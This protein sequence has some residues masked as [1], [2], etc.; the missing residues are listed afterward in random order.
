MFAR[1][2][3]WRMKRSKSSLISSSLIVIVFKF[4]C[5]RGWPR[6]N[7]LRVSPRCSAFTEL[8]GFRFWFIH[9]PDR[10]NQPA[11]IRADVGVI[12]INSSFQT[13]PPFDGETT[14]TSFSSGHRL[15][16]SPRLSRLGVDI[17]LVPISQ[18]TISPFK[19]WKVQDSNLRCVVDLE[20]RLCKRVWSSCLRP[21]GQPSK[22]VF[23]P[24]V[25]NCFV[26]WFL[27]KPANC[28]SGQAIL[29]NLNSNN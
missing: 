14:L 5:C 19:L 24:D 9:R 16:V 12:E 21:L 4:Y 25:V 22:Y 1:M 11:N 18:R 17:F 27:I 29:S 28:H 20:H 26:F 3:S 7:D 23:Y 8:H 10:A 15:L 6:T 13:S 2:A